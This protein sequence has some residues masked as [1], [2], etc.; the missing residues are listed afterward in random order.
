MTEY[1]VKC[2]DPIDESI[3]GVLSGSEFIDPQTFGHAGFICCNCSL[4]GPNKEQIKKDMDVERR[5]AEFVIIGA[6][7]R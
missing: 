2:G 4:F 1:C 6:M 3:P 5:R 7:A